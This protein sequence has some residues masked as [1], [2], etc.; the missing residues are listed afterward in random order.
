MKLSQ[1]A[2]GG[3]LKLAWN[4]ITTGGNHQ[5]KQYY[6]DLY[7]A[8]E[9]AVDA[10]LRDLRQRLLGGAFQPQRPPRIYLPKASGLHRPI[11]LLAIEDQ[12][13]LQAFANLAAKKMHEKRASLQFK[14]LFSNLLQETDSVFFF[15]RWQ[16][17]YA[18]FQRR[19]ERNFDQGLR[20]VGDFDLAAF[21]DTI[22]HEL[23]LRTIYPRTASDDLKWFAQCLQ[24][25][26]SDHASSGHAHGI[27]QG[28]LASDFLAECFLLPIDQ[29]LQGTRGYMRYVD[30]VRLFGATE[31]EVRAS[32]IE[33]ER[34][35]R[36][37]GLIPQTG[38]FAIR[39]VHSVSD[40]LGML[41]SISDPQHDDATSTTLKGTEAL[42]AIRPAIS[43]RPQRVTDKTRLRYALYR[44]EPYSPLLDLVLRLVPRHPEHADV[45]FT[46]LG[47]F[48]YR[49]S[50]E[51]TCLTLIGSSPYDFVRGE[52]WHILA[53]YRRRPT[54]QTTME[55]S[56]LTDRA[57]QVLRSRGR[58][59]VAEQWGA[60]AF[61]C[62]SAEATSTNLSAW[63]QYQI[64]ILQALLA[65]VLPTRAFT[66]SGVVKT[67]LSRTTPEPGLS[68]ASA[69]HERGLT[70]A[71]FGLQEA[72]LPSQVSN[73]LRELGVIGGVAANVD[74]IAEVL[75]ARYGITT[76]KSWSNLLGGQ[77]IHALGLLRQAEATF[78]SGRSSWLTYQNSFNQT[79]FLA[80]QRHLNAA[81]LPGAC[82][83][84]DRN[85]ALVD[86]GVTLDA[87]GPFSRVFP[88][89]GACFRDMNAR[90]NRLPVA[91]PYEKYS[92]AP[93]KYLGAQQ[94]NQFV[95]RLRAAYADFAALMP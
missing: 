13:V 51:S 87:N 63:I 11:S 8:Y 3:N 59:T 45:L 38:K 62:A 73:V 66:P 33:L 37:R 69:M 18:A 20:W 78:D 29:A 64:P 44:A 54:S 76:S 95:A 9:V 12:I 46:Y 27:P 48:G 10:N 55:A 82:K 32:L 57:I 7:F 60:G 35:C 91:H 80:L 41:P 2:A 67:Y 92:A 1:L 5:Y 39:R 31:D 79:V 83:T 28:P 21:Y 30:D 61:A 25:W 24:V 14:V 40:A 53:K 52:A 34:Q 49:K 23:L 4:R 17:T 86:F 85:G 19:I 16:D 26:S 22:S 81:S 70:P 43:G 47:R 56:V 42:A 72:D 6:R 93:T 71:A 94:R 50:I 65:P 75:N 74:P 88:A 77:Y 15:R 68:I 58:E 89:I 90:R 84:I 36:E